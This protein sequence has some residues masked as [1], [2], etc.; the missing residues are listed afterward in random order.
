MPSANRYVAMGSSFAADPGL[1][2]RAKDAPR[3]AGRSQA[4]HLTP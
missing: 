4:P 2:P 1:K 3:L